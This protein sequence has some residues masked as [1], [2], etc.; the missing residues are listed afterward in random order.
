MAARVQHSLLS[1]AVVARATGRLE[2]LERRLRL[3]ASVSRDDG[4]LVYEEVERLGSGESEV[5]RRADGTTVGAEADYVRNYDRRLVGAL[6]PGRD[7]RTEPT[8]S[9]PGGPRRPLGRPVTDPRLNAT[10]A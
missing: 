4:Q 3:W 9:A 5:L 6:A 7:E 1:A 2:V 8:T 10:E